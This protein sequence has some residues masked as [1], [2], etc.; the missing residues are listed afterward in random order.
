[1]PVSEKSNDIKQTLIKSNT[2]SKRKLT[3][4]KRIQCKKLNHAFIALIK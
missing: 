4:L 2:Y 3:L 1:M